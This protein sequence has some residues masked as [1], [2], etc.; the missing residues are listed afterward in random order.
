MHTFLHIPNA[1][2]NFCGFSQVFEQ[3]DYPSF[4]L[5]GPVCVIHSMRQK[6]CFNALC[7]LYSSPVIP[8]L[9]W[10]PFSFQ[11]IQQP[12]NTLKEILIISLLNP[13]P[14][15][16]SLK[17]KFFDRSKYKNFI[18]SLSVF[19]YGAALFSLNTVICY[20]QISCET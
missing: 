11:L 17:L 12:V 8:W 9:F 1:F 6:H 7:S 2:A 5:R 19:F 13:T 14:P 3:I 18:L 10:T 16:I 20:C 4:S 15:P